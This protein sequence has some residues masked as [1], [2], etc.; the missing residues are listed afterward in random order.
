M[1]HGKREIFLKRHGKR[2]FTMIELLIVLMIFS[3]VTALFIAN[4]RRFG[5]NVTLANVADEVALSIREMQTYGLASKDTSAAGS[6]FKKAYGIHIPNVSDYYYM[7]EDRVAADRKYTSGESISQ[8]RLPSGMTIADKCVVSGSTYPH[9]N[10]LH[11]TFR[12]PDADATIYG[13]NA[14]ATYQA[15][16]ICLESSQT[17]TEKVVTVSQAGQ[18]EVI[19]A[20]PCQ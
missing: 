10:S 5:N 17:N 19:D 3:I 14:T 8:Y 13:D 2:G 15:A 4:Y 18:I 11:V 1:R 7:F 6:D 16:Y 9:Q 20:C 12:R